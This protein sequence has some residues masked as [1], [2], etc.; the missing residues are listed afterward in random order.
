LQDFA[1]LAQ[2][3]FIDDCIDCELLSTRD[4]FILKI[5]Y[6]CPGSVPVASPVS[7]FPPDLNIVGI[8][9]SLIGRKMP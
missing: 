9:D 6:V 2:D 3:F 8:D 5:S 1:K 7:S 4:K